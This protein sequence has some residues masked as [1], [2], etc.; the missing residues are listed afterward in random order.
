MD[1]D[2]QVIGS[3]GKIHNYIWDDKESKMVEGKREKNIPWWKLH[4]IAK[5]LGGEVKSFI[6]QDSRGNVTKRLVI[7][8]TEEEEE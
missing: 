4:Q 2:Y 6:I 1:Y 5:E 7:E 8:Y 3:D